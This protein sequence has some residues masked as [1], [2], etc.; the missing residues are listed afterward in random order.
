[1]EPG[2]DVMAP[3]QKETIQKW[4]GYH[5]TSASD[6]ELLSVLNIKVDSE[7]DLPNWAKNSLAKWALDEKISMKE[8]IN[9]IKY[10]VKK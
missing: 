6:S 2:V 7:P 4:A 5:V 3:D 1:M 8:F 10:F 9:A